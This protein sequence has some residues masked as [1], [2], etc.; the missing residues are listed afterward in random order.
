MNHKKSY[1][2]QQINLN[3]LKTASNYRQRNGKTFQEKI[4]VLFKRE[5]ISL[6]RTKSERNKNYNENEKDYVCP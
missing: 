5:I 4:V 1:L 3:I 2:L 6:Q